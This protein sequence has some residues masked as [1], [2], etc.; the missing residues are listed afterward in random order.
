MS[1]DGTRGSFAKELRRIQ[2]AYLPLRGAE[3]GINKAEWEGTFSCWNPRYYSEL[4]MYVWRRGKGYLKL[5][6]AEK[7]KKRHPST[8]HVGKKYRT[9]IF[10]Q[11]GHATHVINAGLFTG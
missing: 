9:V 3:M 4:Y 8:P 1:A 7:T 5:S 11:E 2:N 10:W 6:K